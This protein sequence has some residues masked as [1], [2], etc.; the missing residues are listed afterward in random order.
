VKRDSLAGDL[1]FLRYAEAYTLDHAHHGNYVVAKVPAVAPP[2]DAGSPR[3][4]VAVF[5]CDNRYESGFHELRSLALPDSNKNPSGKPP[6]EQELTLE[7]ARADAELVVIDKECRKGLEPG[8]T[9]Q[10]LGTRGKTVL[11]ARKR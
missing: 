6:L 8:N 3:D 2:D 4:L 1:A 5:G 9:F 10:K 11:Y 7:T